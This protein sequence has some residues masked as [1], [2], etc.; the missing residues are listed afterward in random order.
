MHDTMKVEISRDVKFDE[1]SYSILSSKQGQAS[2]DHDLTTSSDDEKPSRPK[3]ENS[4]TEHEEVFQF[5]SNDFIS[6]VGGIAGVTIGLSIWSLY[7]DFF[8]P[9]LTWIEEKIQKLTFQNIYKK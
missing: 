7:I 1:L 2:E 5:N 8:A 3:E 6:D 9:V 4:A